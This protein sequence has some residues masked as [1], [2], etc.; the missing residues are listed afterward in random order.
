LTGQ[1]VVNQ[2]PEKKERETHTQLLKV[3][4]D[5]LCVDDV[6]I[7]RLVLHFSLF[8]FFFQK[9]RKR[10]EEEEDWRVLTCLIGWQQK[11]S[12]R[13]PLRSFFFFCCCPVRYDAI[14]LLCV[15]FE[16]PVRCGFSLYS[17]ASAAAAAAA[18]VY[19]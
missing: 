11:A 6:I 16:P 8:F 4:E 13:L 17:T 12:G 9:I 18:Q 19:K 1:P 2:V 15:I 5:K 10:K 14:S 3:E 7:K